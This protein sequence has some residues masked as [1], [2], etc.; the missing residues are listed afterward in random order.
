MLQVL[1]QITSK[2]FIEK[3]TQF[4]VVLS[5]CYDMGGGGPEGGRAREEGVGGRVCGQGK[6]ECGKWD[7]WKEGGVGEVFAPSDPNIPKPSLL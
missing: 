3:V 5:E 1:V 6:K 7:A 2:H 4:V